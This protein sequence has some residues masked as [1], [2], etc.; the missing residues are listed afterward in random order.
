[1]PASQEHLYI[2]VIAKAAIQLQLR[3]DS[4]DIPVFLPPG[5]M[6]EL[7]IISPYILKTNF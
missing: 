5:N 1:M 2:F 6:V 4:E 7:L 3:L